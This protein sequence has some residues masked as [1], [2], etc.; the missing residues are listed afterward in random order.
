M[1]GSISSHVRSYLY[2]CGSHVQEPIGPQPFHA[3]QHHESENS[4]AMA[5]RVSHADGA[6]TCILDKVCSLHGDMI[7]LTFYCMLGCTF[8][9][10][11]V[12]CAVL[13]VICRDRAVLASSAAL[14][15]EEGEAQSVSVLR[16]SACSP[17]HEALSL[18]TQQE[19][20][21]VFILPTNHLFAAGTDVSWS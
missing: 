1:Y 6:L 7:S 18:P 10:T 5:E 19:T 16:A 20:S 9:S 15:L 14:K 2:K 12:R 21:C 17:K 3:L 8:S 11:L 4:I 13:C